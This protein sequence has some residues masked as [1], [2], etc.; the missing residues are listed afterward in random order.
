VASIAAPAEASVTASAVAT[1]PAEPAELEPSEP[2]A[3]PVPLPLAKRHAALRTAVPLP[4]PKPS[5]VAPEP[6]LPAFDRHVIN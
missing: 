3:G 5:N 2:I 6:D 4:R 1:E